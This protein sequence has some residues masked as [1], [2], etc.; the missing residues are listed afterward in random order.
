MNCLEIKLTPDE[1]RMFEFKMY[2]YNGIQIAVNQF[3][4]TNALSYNEEHY[5]RLTDTCIEKHRN[6]TE[7]ILELLRNRKYTDI[8]IQKMSYEYTRGSLKVYMQ[9]GVQNKSIKF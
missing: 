2:Q 9:Q 3:M 4:A 6:L 5:K 1:E 8:P 7:Y